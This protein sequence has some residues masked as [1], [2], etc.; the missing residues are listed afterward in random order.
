MNVV[1]GIDSGLGGVLGGGAVGGKG[2][3]LGNYLL[4]SKNVLI[5]VYKLVQ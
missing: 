4:T 3:G 2:T 1:P 5:Y